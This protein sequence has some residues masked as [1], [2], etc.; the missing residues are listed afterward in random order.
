[1]TVT[2]DSSVLAARGASTGTLTPGWGLA[3]NTGTPGSV[4]ISMASP[5]GSVSGSGILANIE[6]DVVGAPGTQTDLIISSLALNDGAIVA[7][8][9]NGSF[10]VHQA[11]SISGTVTFWNGGAG[12]EGTLL[13]LTGNSVYSG[14]SSTHGNLLGHGFPRRRLHHGAVQV[15]R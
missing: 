13:T 6:F 9:A 15:R 1:M 5:A 11:L 3:V 2:F 8:Q 10:T 4:R 14:T 7:L 12:V